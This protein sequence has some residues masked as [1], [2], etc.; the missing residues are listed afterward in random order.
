[1]FKYMNK[2]DKQQ[3]NE[4]IE[5]FVVATACIS[6]VVGITIYM[7]IS[8]GLRE[9]ETLI[10]WLIRAGGLIII[11]IFLLIIYLLFIQSILKWFKITKNECENPGGIV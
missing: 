8:L 10:D 5:W 6:V 7:F 2:K 4:M 3:A 1:M 11:N 9:G